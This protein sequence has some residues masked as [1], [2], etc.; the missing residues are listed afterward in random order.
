[1]NGRPRRRLPTR[2]RAVGGIGSGAQRGLFLLLAEITGGSACREL[3]LPPPL[4]SSA[5]TGCGGA[6]LRPRC[7]RA[8]A[9]S[10]IAFVVVTD[11]HLGYK[12]Q[13]TA[14][15]VWLQTASGRRARLCL[16]LGDVVDGGREAQY[17]R[18]L[19]GRQLT[20]KPVHEI[21]GNH[22]P[23]ELFARHLRQEVDMALEHEW[24]RVLL[25]NNSH[26]SS[27]DGFIAPAQLGWLSEQCDLA[28]RKNQ[29]LLYAM[30]VPVHR[31]ANPIVSGSYF[32][33]VTF[34][35]VCAAGTIARRSTRSA[36]P[37]RSTI[38][39]VRSM[40]RGAGL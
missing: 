18:S 19:A 21:P 24:L 28:A 29:L 10:E 32:S 6:V 15:R 17:A 2:A 8:V 11:T 40:R 27:H 39:T 36:F 34:T 33:T 30:H 31:N 26:P 12:G 1:M 9:R 23:Q 7:L 4:S 35:T 5:R 16:H 14:E 20:R 3:F 38:K 37:R 13:D 22:D 25:I